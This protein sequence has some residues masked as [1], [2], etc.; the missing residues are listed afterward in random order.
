LRAIQEKAVRP[1]GSQQE[2]NVDVRILSATHKDLSEMVSQNEF[3]QDLYYRINVIELVIPPL[4]ERAEDIDMLTSH[5]LEKLA[6][7]N[8]VESLAIAKAARKRLV[9]YNFP[10]NVRELE[11]IL[12]RASAL[13]DNDEIQ[14]EDLSLP[15][16]I[17]SLH[18]DGD[19][20]LDD[21]LV[22]HEKEAIQ[23]ALEK[24]R[25]NKTRAAEMLGISF[26]QLRYRLKKL[27]IK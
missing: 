27:N 6:I 18:D 2:V 19:L 23:K 15:E 5:I 11:N 3:R 26:R 14:V 21:L 7:Q 16:N 24:T 13:C 9:H 10:G 22:Q 17:M 8:G 20:M 4:R 25:F 1:V 12:E